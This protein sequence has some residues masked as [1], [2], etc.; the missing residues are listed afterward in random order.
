[1]HDAS[2]SRFVEAM[3]KAKWPTHYIALNSL[4]GKSRALYM[5]GYPSFKAWEDDYMATMKNKALSTELDKAS[6]AD[7][8]LLA[9]IDQFVFVYNEETTIGPTP[10]WP[11]RGRL[12]SPRSASSPGTAKSGAIL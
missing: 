12:R 6:V 8:E 10:I 3:A 1:M 4:S 7:G 2:E 5:T 11:T 9:N